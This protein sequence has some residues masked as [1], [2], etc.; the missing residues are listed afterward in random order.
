MSII[1]EKWIDE[2]WR[3]LNKKLLRIAES[4][5][6]T[7]P[8]TTREG[9]LY[10]DMLQTDVNWWTNGF[11]PGM[12]WLMYSGT[13]NEDFRKTAENAEILLDGALKN[14]DGLHHDVG[15]M[16]HIS[17]GANYSL[18]GNKKSYVR[19]MYA[20]NVLAG[21]YNLKGEYI[22]AW[23]GEG[24]NGYAII[25]CMMN[26]PLL[27]WASRESGD[28]RYK[29][30]AMS[31]ADKT[32]KHH[33]RD[34]GS[35]HHIVN[36]NPE[37]G[38]VENVISGQGY[39]EGSSWSRGQAWGLYGFVISYIHTGEEKYLNTAKKIANYFIAASCDDYLPKSDFRSPKEPVLYD[40]SAG[41]IAAC[42][43]IELSKAVPEYESLMYYNSA[44]KFIK[45]IVDTFADWSEDSDAIITHCSENYNAQKHLT[46]VYA[47]FFLAEAMNKLKGFNVFLW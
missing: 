32:L 29:Y 22:R 27:Y 46:L 4:K 14:Y 5:R 13:K 9:K 33:V 40:C 20:A 24:Q 16:W 3:K 6:G 19:N 1:D 45:A 15:F 42:G 38:E 39:G 30:I 44:L 21:R 34:D 8:Y 31:H 2:T 10:D 18:T 12:M 26:L 11:W 7:L 35:V 47:D 41:L 17:A 25:D 43:L 36:Y 28:E 37:T 23:N